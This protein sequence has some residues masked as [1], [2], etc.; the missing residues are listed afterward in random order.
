M[1]IEF[2]EVKEIFEEYKQVTANAQEMAI[3]TRD[4]DLQK[5]AMFEL[6]AFG[7]KA[8]GVKNLNKNRFSEFE[9]NLILFLIIT[10]EAV[11]SEILMIVSLKENLMEQAWAALVQAQTK[12]SISAAN[13]PI[14]KE[15]FVPYIDRLEAYERL[16]FPKMMFASVGGIIKQT[17]CSICGNSY[18]DCDHMKGKMYGGELCVREIH[19]MQL[20]EVSLVENP[21]NK[22]CRTITA[23]FNGKTVDP[24][25][26]KEIALPDTNTINDA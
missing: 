20:E 24:L 25:T 15:D 3:F 9:L 19:E 13:H 17:K 18:E 7:K 4:I 22:M 5:S 2:I 12:I 16:L 23:T 8:Q 14:N 26:L 10:A 11:G 6:E 21:A 1:T